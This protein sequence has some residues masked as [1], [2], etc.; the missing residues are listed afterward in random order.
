MSTSSPVPAPIVFGKK[1]PKVFLIQSENEEVVAVFSLTP[2]IMVLSVDELATNGFSVEMSDISS[3]SRV[4]V[5]VE[6]S[7]PCF[8]EVKG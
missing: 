7:C 6:K 1:I 3:R 4:P 5:E 8:T 2:C